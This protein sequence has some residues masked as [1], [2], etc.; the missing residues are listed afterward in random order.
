MIINPD[1]DLRQW[2]EHLMAARVRGAGLDESERRLRKQN[3]ETVRT[4]RSQ[5]TQSFYPEGAN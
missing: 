5:R 3:S 1:W 2:G 4:A